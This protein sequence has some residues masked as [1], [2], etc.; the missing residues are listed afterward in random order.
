[1][2]NLDGPF[3]KVYKSLKEFKLTPTELLIYCQIVEYIK[4]TGTCYMTDAQFAEEY[5]ISAKTVSRTLQ[6]LEDKKLISRYTITQASKRVRLLTLYNETDK[7][8]V[9]PNFETDDLSVSTGTDSKIQ[10]KMSV[11]I[12]LEDNKN[13]VKG[14]FCLNETDKMS[15]PY[16]QNDFIKDN[17]KINIKD[18]SCAPRFEVSLT[19]LLK[20]FIGAGTLENPYIGSRDAIKTI[21]E[22]NPMGANYLP[23]KN[24]LMKIG[25]YFYK[26]KI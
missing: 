17:K 15:R 20:S 23:L 18:N 6:V 10:D 12:P 25:N 26:I 4:N 5:N 9:S 2:P 13:N 14:T 19:E 1:M 24:G 11:S 21:L 22:N 16:G 8:T 3:L 7:M